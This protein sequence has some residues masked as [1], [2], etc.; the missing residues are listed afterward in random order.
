VRQAI[1]ALGGSGVRQVVASID[2][3]DPFE[4][5]NGTAERYERFRRHA[6]ATRHATDRIADLARLPER[7]ELAV[8]ALLH[9][10]GRLVMA[11]MYQ[12]F[13]QPDDRLI[14]PDERVR[15]ERRELGIDHFDEAV[16]TVEEGCTYISIRV[17]RSGPSGA[18]AA[19]EIASEDNTAK[20]KGDYT[21]VAGRLV[22]APGE[23]EKTFEVLINDDNYT[24]GL[25]FATLILQH[26]EGGT[27]GV[28]GTATLQITDDLTEDPAN[29]IDDSRAFVSHHYHDF[30]YRQSDQAGEDFW[31]QQI[32][33][34][35]ADALCRQ[36]KRID[37]SVAF[38]LSI[39]FQQTGYLVIRAH[40]AAF[41]NIESNPR[42]EIFLR[43]Q[44]QLG[45]GVIV[46]QPGFEQL[47]DANRQ[48]YLEAFVSRAE[49]IQQFPQGQPAANYV[50]ALFANV[51]ATPAPDERDAAI[52]AYGAGDTAGSR[53]AAR[54]AAGSAGSRDASVRRDSPGRGAG[55]LR[56]RHRRR[57]RR[58]RRGP[59]ACP[60]P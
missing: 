30:L 50:D 51:G 49:F 48:K 47:L 32:E 43:D 23:T 38:F 9:D 53:D 11:D 1:D 6:V 27:I 15:Y 28:P 4:S 34:C 13:D 52:S 20:Q 41:G 54:S 56:R 59:P 19:V 24:E 31:T 29:P 58:R 35:G 39:E 45:A 55:P 21:L 2:T 22:F 42:Y 33:S 7:D 46:G 57:R 14:A 5:P 40:K 26:P 10:V 37:V 12:L 8:A 25:E 3:Y 44:R 18:A 17:L 16:Y 36:G 60:R